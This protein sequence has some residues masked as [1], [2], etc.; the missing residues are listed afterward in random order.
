MKFLIVILGLLPCCGYAEAFVCKNN[1][2]LSNIYTQFDGPD[3]SLFTVDNPDKYPDYL[4]IAKH[5]S[6]CITEIDQ[7]Y[8]KDSIPRTRMWSADTY[9][10]ASDSGGNSVNAQ[11]KRSLIVVKKDKKKYAGAF[12]C[13]EDVDHDGI[14]DFCK[15]EERMGENTSHAEATTYLVK[16]VL[17]NDQ[18]VVEK[19]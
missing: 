16:L 17:K 19:Q 7:T 12:S 6:G 5:K 15:V 2:D 1:Y 8:D 18:L 10:F 11:N 4:V 9:F 14:K 3:F 13:V